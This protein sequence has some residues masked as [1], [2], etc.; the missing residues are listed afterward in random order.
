MPVWTCR[1][2]RPADDTELASARITLVNPQIGDQLSLGALP[3]GIELDTSSTSANLILTGNG[4]LADYTTAISGTTFDN[5]APG[6]TLGDRTIEVVVNDGT[7]DSATA[8]STV[9][10]ASASTISF[11]TIADTPYSGS[12]AAALSEYFTVIPQEAEFVIHLGDIKSGTSSCTLDVYQNV[13]SL[14]QGSSVPVFIIPGD[15]EYNDCSNPDAAFANWQTEFSF[16][17]Q[18]WTH[19][20]QVS[21]QTIR[22]ENFAFVFNGTLF[23]GINLVGG[24]IHDAQEWADRSADDL[25]WIESNFAQFGGQVTSAVI[26]GHASPTKSAYALFEQGFRAAAQE[27]GDPILY[28]QG[29]EHKWLLDQP[30]ADA[31]NVTRI[32]IEQTGGGADSDPLLVSVSGDPTDPFTYDHDFGLIA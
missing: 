13:S 27:L 20:F 24:T 29:D 6:G 14:L 32:I 8:V 25:V 3:A 31:P 1:W 17:D 15:N 18:N 4:S 16:F 7:T 12:Q 21:Y 10:V 22:E 5:T 9:S 30:F 23:I 11:W 28:L 2:K 26:F 19:D